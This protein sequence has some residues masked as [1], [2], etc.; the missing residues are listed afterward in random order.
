M[1]FL[2]SNSDK[3]E[4]FVQIFQIL[5]NWSNHI[6]LSIFRDKLT[7]QM[8]DKSK[9]CLADITLDKDWFT[10]YSSDDTDNLQISI[11]STLFA[12]LMKFAPQNKTIEVKYN[13]TDPDNIHVSFLNPGQ[14]DH[15]YTLCL[16]EVEHESLNIPLVEYD[17]DFSLQSE[18]LIAVCNELCATGSEFKIMCDEN[19][20][21]FYTKGD[22]TTLKLTVSV[23][24]LD[25]YSM[26]SDVL[27]L[28]VSF[29]VSHVTKLCLSKKI[30]ESLCVSVSNSY[31]MRIKYEFDA[32]SFVSFYIAPKL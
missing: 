30:S 21:E 11:D 13:E 25:E 4:T 22:T 20:V 24:D 1:H 10:S 26:T 27:D 3:L 16:I 7:M 5:K 12:N 17:V 9:V 29:S 2:I 31:P 28:N 19:N 18:K 15:Y 32:K 8:M 14:F 23:D 6:T